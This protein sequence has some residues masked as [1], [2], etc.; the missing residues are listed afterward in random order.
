MSRPPRKGGILGPAVFVAAS[1][2]YG[3]LPFV[4]ALARMRGVDLRRVGSRTVGGSNLWQQ[5][6]PA[7]GAIGWFLDAS[8]G[9]LPPLVGRRLGMGPSTGVVG[10]AAGVAGQCW[11]VFLGFDGG[12]GVSAVLGAAAALAPRELALALIP[13]VGGCTV[14]A[15]SVLR[16]SAG[17]A[18]RDRLRLQGPNSKIVPLSVGIGSLGIPLLAVLRYQSR[19]VVFGTAVNAALLFARRATAGADEPTRGENR[20][21]INRL[22]YDRSTSG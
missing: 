22:L 18:P 10:A 11:P 8:K 14:R 6:G 13:I 16:S 2:V 9:A 4:H 5:A 12:R 3:S 21:V 19:E 20:T 17:G 15:A 1:Y 7:P